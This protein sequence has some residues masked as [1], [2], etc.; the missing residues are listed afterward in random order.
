MTELTKGDKK[1][2][3]DIEQHGWHVVLVGGD[4]TGPGFGYSVGLYTTFNHPEIIIIGL[5]FDLMHILINN[6]G[7]EIRSGKQYEADHYYDD[8]LDNYQCLMVKVDK[9]YYRDYVGYN[10]WYYKGEDFP[11][12]Q[13]IYPTI[14]GVYPWQ[15]EWP[16]GIKDLQPILNK[17]NR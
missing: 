13:C 4:E 11:L 3:S 6:I 5:K 12:L 7:E 1:L 9:Q 15:K 10:L 8:I 16:E 2:L 17:E 14:K